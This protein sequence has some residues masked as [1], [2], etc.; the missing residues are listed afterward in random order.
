MTLESARA[1]KDY[2]ERLRPQ[3]PDGLELSIWMDE[4]R[5]L[6]G[7][8]NA[9]TSSAWAGLALVML[10]LTMF[11]RFKVALW[12]AAGIPIAV[13]GALWVFPAAGINISSLTVLAFI[14]VLGIV[15][16]DAIVVG[17]RVFSHET[18]DPNHR[19]AA[20]AGTWEVAI[21]VIF[22]V[23]TTVAAF[24]PIL[25]IEGNMGTLLDHWLGRRR[26]PV[27]QSGGITA[28]FT[29]APRPSAYRRLPVSEFRFRQGLDPLSGRLRK[30]VGMVC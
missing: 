21:P 23:L 28:Y 1:V 3:L 8:I 4:S 27:L 6:A 20:I 15:V 26:L 13:L 11:L 25:L 16:D 22:G 18:T 29:L 19:E 5:S 14:L 7:R 10:I 17:E 30:F 9:L 2:V 24:L 12:V